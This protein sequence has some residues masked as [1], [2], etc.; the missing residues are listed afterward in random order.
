MYGLSELRAIFNAGSAPEPLDESIV[1]VGWL[2]ITQEL[3]LV[4]PEAPVQA[5]PFKSLEV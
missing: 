1:K 2:P 5:V 3:G 4:V